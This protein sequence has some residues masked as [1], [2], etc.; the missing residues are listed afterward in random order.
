M[1][2][3]GWGEREISHQQNQ[4]VMKTLSTF[5]NCVVGMEFEED[6]RFVDE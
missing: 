1:L 2:L 4:R 3:G 5:W 6:L